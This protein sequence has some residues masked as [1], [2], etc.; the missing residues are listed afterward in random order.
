[1]SKLRIG[2]ESVLT[3]TLVV[4]AGYVALSHALADRIPIQTRIGNVSFGGLKTELVDRAMDAYERD[5]MQTQVTITFRNNERTYTFESLGMKLDKEKTAEKIR[6]LAGRGIA[7]RGTTI[8]PEM[9]LQETVTRQVLQKD[10][11]HSMVLAKF[12]TLELNAD[13]TIRVLPATNGETIDTIALHRDITEAFPQ[14]SVRRVAAT[15]IRTAPQADMREIERTREF[16]QTLLASGFHLT[17]PEHTFTILPHAVAGMIVFS[18]DI[19]PVVRF[20]EAKLRAYILQDVVSQVHQDPVNARF[21]MVDGR[22]SQFALP[23]EGREMNVDE[24]METVTKALA[25]HIQTAPISVQVVQPLISDTGDSERLG[26]TTLLATGESDFAGSPKNRIKNIEVGASKYNGILIAPNEEFS[27]NAFLGPVTKEAGFLP[28]LVIKNNVTTPE[29][30]GGLCQV[31][32]TVFRAAVHSGMQ[33]TSRRNHSYAV[34]Y[35]GTPGFDATIYPPY[36]DFRFLNNTPG[37]ILIQ[38]KIDGTKLFFEFW[39][40]DDNRSVIVDGP[41]PYGRK[42]DGSV[43]SVVKQTVIKDDETII[44]DTFYSNYKSPNLFPRT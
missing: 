6:A 22:V 41:S 11:A 3:A 34:Q 38:T 33:I 4:A 14:I 40:T 27:F 2:L 18:G 29:F 25:R 8:L 5:F 16:A 35:Y 24:T 23:Q 17:V 37:Y 15:A 10:F 44:E 26:V 9:T 19:S 13:N 7:V 12:P 36:T 32:T 30:G 42:P 21:Q 43:K 31:S 39:G 1:M 20:D 28:E